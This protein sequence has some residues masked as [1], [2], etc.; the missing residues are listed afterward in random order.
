[1]RLLKSIRPLW[2]VVLLASLAVAGVLATGTYYATATPDCASCHGTGSF[3]AAT[4]ASAHAQVPCT[5]CHIPAGKT[6]KAAFGIRVLTQMTL[7]VVPSR[8]REGAFVAD[9]QCLKCHAKAVDTGVVTNNGVRVQHSTCATGVRC[10]DCHSTVAHGS[11]TSWATSYDM[12]SCLSCHVSK[13]STACDT[14]HEGRRPAERIAVGTFATTHGP[15]WRKTH[16][17]GN[18][19]TCTT[20]HTNTT[21]G[22]CHGAGLP[23]EGTFIKEHGA[24]S[25]R[26][27]AKCQTCHE[28]TFCSDCHGTPMPHSN[29]FTKTHSTAASTDRALCNRCHAKSD[30]E[31]CHVKHVHPGGA[32]GKG[33]KQGGAR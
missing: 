5:S 31:T 27:D 15:Q 21:C 9:D 7:H 11:K 1:M 6:S 4:Q 8:G 22:R 20:C 25:Q 33:P 14:C 26:S 12:E 23:H 2:L 16:G 24:I 18:A 32:I 3:A 17:M 30:C 29:R 19:A 13:A 10:A 28:K